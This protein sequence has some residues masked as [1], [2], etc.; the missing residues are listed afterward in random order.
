MKVN[1]NESHLI[2]QA[3]AT[4]TDW[5]KVSTNVLK[6]ITFHPEK[7][8]K[9]FLDFLK[10]FDIDP[11]IINIKRDFE[12]MP[13][14][15]FASEWKLIKHYNKS[16]EIQSL[17]IKNIRLEKTANSENENISGYKRMDVLIK[18]KFIPLD[19]YIFL[20]FWRNQYLIPES[21]KDKTNGETT[22]ICFDGTAFMSPYNKECTLFLYWMKDAWHYRQFRLEELTGRNILSAVLV[23]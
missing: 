17:N 14:K 16:L 23:A 18:R 20:M 12:I 10:T 8:G 3:L 2:M 19:I 1:T 13:D 5:E 22:F 7:T 15:L 9:L 4:N 6:Q 21:W 11:D